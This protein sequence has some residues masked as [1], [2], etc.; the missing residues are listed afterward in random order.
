MT[1]DKTD[2]KN[3]IEYY[4]E[5]NKLSVKCIDQNYHPSVSFVYN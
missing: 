4:V 5:D 3:Q 2:S 1:E